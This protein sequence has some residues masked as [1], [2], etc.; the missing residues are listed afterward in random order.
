MGG[1]LAR[2][3]HLGEVAAL[4][5]SPGFL[6]GLLAAGA[7]MDLSLHLGPIPA[8]VAARTLEWQKVRFESA[9]SLSLRKGQEPL[10]GGGDRARG[11]DAA[12]RRGA[13]GTR[14][15]LSRLALAYAARPR[16][17]VPRR[18]LRRRRRRTSPRPSASSTRSPSASARDCSPPSHWAST[19]SPPGT[20]STPP[21]WRRSI[22]SRRPTWTRAGATCAASTCGRRPRSSTTPGTAPTSTPTRP[23]SRARARENRSRP[24]WA[25][26]AASRAASSPT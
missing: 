14:A 8:A 24:S 3:L 17:R 23:S 25:C 5:Q 19:P 4:P 21:R 16:R 22:P 26:C 9:Q 18:R 7:P 1:H 11:R 6:Q 13:A 10:L 2:S 20:R 12:A 15:P